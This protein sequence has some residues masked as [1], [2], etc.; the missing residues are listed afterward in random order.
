MPAQDR[1]PAD[2]WEDWHKSRR[3][4]HLVAHTGAQ[5][6]WAQA[7]AAIGVADRYIKHVT[8]KVEAALKNPPPA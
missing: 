8:E 6:T 2:W 4:R 7:E 5:M 3:D 1:V